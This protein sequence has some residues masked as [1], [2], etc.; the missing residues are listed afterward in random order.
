MFVKLLVGVFA[1]AV[2]GVG[3]VAYYHHV[4]DGSHCCPLQRMASGDEP[5]SPCC[6]RAAPSPCSD[7][8]NCCKD[9]EPETLTIEPREIK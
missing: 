5:T 7:D 4:V 8:N 1:T 6:Q 9:V 2:L 3:S